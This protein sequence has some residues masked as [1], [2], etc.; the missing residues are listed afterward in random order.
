MLLKAAIKFPGYSDIVVCKISSLDGSFRPPDFVRSL[1]VV[2]FVVTAFVVV[3]GVA[4]FVVVL[5]RCFLANGRF[6]EAR[7]EEPRKQNIRVISFP[8]GTLRKT[9]VTTIFCN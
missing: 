6:A 1:F 9:C 4:V 5:F 7:A 8:G 3:V 2:T